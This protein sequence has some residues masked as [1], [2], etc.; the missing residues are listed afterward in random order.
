M[1]DPELPA[2]YVHWRAAPPKPPNAP[3]VAGLLSQPVG[4]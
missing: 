4:S 1:S 2:P 3:V